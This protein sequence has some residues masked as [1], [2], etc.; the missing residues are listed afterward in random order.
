MQK[1]EDQIRKYFPKE[2]ALLRFPRDF[3]TY[4]NREFLESLSSDFTIRAV[5]LYGDWDSTDFDHKLVNILDEVPTP[6][7][8]YLEGSCRDEALELALTADLRIASS[9][10]TFQ[11]SY[12]SQGRMPSNGATP[13]LTRIVGTAQAMRLLL[14]SEQINAT[15][16]TRIGLVQ[17]IGGLEEVSKSIKLIASA[18]PI[19]ARYTKESIKASLEL[20]AFQAQRLENDL[21]VL[22]QSTEDRKEG[23]RSYFRKENPDFRSR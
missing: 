1:S 22:L 7:I 10:A 13:R 15:E 21:S 3:Q 19:A 4:W 9:D 6:V 5:V 20:S 11:F 8:A 23:L 17:V 16:S 2:I 14:S 12:V 18:A